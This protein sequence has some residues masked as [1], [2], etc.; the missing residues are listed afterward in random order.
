MFALF[1]DD[2]TIIHGTAGF[3]AFG[4]S[5]SGYGCSPSSRTIL[6]SFMGPQ[7]SLPSASQP[8]VMDVRPL[9]GRFYHYSWDRR[10]RCLRHL[11]QRLFMFALFEDDFTIIHWTA[12]FA[13]FGSSTSGY[14][15]SPSSRTFW[16][17]TTS[18]AAT[19]ARGNNRLKCVHYALAKVP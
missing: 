3:A 7:A 5:T 13:A 16:Q 14:G 18:S 4:S 17:A 11:N 8:A 6:P 15:C 12:G 9:R 2:F 10:L 1:E 19:L